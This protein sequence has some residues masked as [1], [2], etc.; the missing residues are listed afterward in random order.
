MLFMS[1]KT[2]LVHLAPDPDRETRLKAAVGIAK[3]L[4][5]HLIAL[6]V[7]MPV[8][9]PAGAEGRGASSLYLH[10]AR[11]AAKEK[12][13]A[14]E[15]QVREFCDSAGISWEWAYG[16]EDHLEHLLEEVYHV[17][18]TVLNQ[19]SFDNFED[20]LIYQLPEKLVMGAGGPVLV[21]P[22]GVDQVDLK[23]F[24]SVLIAWTY[25]KEAIRALRDSLPMIENAKHVK[26]FTCGKA[27]KVGEDLAKPVLEYLARRGIKADH[28]NHSRSGHAGE[29]ILDL[30]DEVKAD[31]IVMG[32]YGHSSMLDKL[33]GSASRYVIGHSKVPL[34]MSH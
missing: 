11:S 25:T 18:L 20:R 29:E 24:D 33:F 17:D 26:L 14:I 1:I 9:M 21:L 8:H 7:A 6:Y 3:Q 5:A 31:L 23:S 28:I 4:D 32:A 34:L 30:A 19:V 10:E 2:L 22:K 12:A 27:P 15:A 16:E 13:G